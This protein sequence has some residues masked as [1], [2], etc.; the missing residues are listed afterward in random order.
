MKVLPSDG[1]SSARRI[2][3][4]GIALLGL[5]GCT[6]ITIENDGET[7][8]V[9]A[10]TSRL[11]GGAAWLTGKAKEAAC[12]G[13][14]MTFIPSP[15]PL[16]DELKKKLMGLDSE[17][18][19]PGNAGSSQVKEI[20]ALADLVNAVDHLHEAVKGWLGRTTVKLTGKCD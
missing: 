8:A 9:I 13:T 3:L 2:A 20:G 4:G 12:S 14:D 17:N 1:L 5:V 6:S 7:V 10:E 19:N 16:S 11:I 15:H 18:Q